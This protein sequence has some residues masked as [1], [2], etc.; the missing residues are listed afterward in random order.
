MLMAPSVLLRLHVSVPSPFML[1]L[2]L[3]SHCQA[4]PLRGHRSPSA[5]NPGPGVV[6][7]VASLWHRC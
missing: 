4:L 2:L 7:F 1:S 5:G 6:F 3:P